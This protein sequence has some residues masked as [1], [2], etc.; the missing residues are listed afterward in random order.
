[1]GNYVW[2]NYELIKYENTSGISELYIINKKKQA[3]LGEWRE[4]T[5]EWMHRLGYLITSIKRFCFVSC[6]LLE[7]VMHHE[8]TSKAPPP[9]F[10]RVDFEVF[11]DFFRAVT[12]HIFG[13]AY[14]VSE[15]G[16]GVSWFE[17]WCVCQSTLAWS[18]EVYRRVNHIHRFISHRQKSGIIEEQQEASA[19]PT[20]N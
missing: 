20:V 7:D 11:N 18:S 2:R 6:L 9:F 17:A 10:W 14:S 12:L 13:I 19:S 16:W 5:E 4:F 3:L 15:R 1:M 8:T